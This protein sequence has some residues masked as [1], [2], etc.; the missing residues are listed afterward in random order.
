MERI[1]KLAK[2]YARLEDSVVAVYAKGDGSFGFGKLCDV[3][4]RP[5]LEYI[6]PY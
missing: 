1:R 2:A 3:P 5:V 4:G 6:T